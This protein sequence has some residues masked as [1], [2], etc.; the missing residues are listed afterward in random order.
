MVP[1]KLL[2]R[3]SRRGWPDCCVQA[4]A[5]NPSAAIIAVRIEVRGTVR[6]NIANR[7]WK[8]TSNGPRMKTRSVY[9]T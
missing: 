2:V 4:T 8:G 9:K 3:S 6:L 5:Q 1:Y 7:Y